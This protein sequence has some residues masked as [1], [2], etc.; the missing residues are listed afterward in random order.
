MLKENRP[1]SLSRNETTKQQMSVA[2]QTKE[3]IR[4]SLESVEKRRTWKYLWELER[5]KP[6]W[7]HERSLKPGIISTSQDEATENHSVR[8]VPAAAAFQNK[9]L[10][11]VLLLSVTPLSPVGV[12]V[13]V[14]GL[15]VNNTGHQVL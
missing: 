2:I 5:N 10:C 8:K 15:L 9:S 3:S 14:G 7:A 12:C 11:E 1:M 4:F 13:W 6:R